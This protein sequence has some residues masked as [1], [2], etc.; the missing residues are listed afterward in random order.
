[1]F[2]KKYYLSALFC[3][4]FPFTAQAD[5]TEDNSEEEYNVIEGVEA[6]EIYRR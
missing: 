4:F 6:V 1:M 5:S 3:A 2:S